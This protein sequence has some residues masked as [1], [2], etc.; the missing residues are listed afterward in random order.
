MKSLMVSRSVNVIYCVVD[1][2]NNNAV[3]RILEQHKMADK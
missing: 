1:V 2:M 3:V